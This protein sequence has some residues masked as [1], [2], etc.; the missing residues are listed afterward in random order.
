MDWKDISSIVGK[1]APIVG[2]LLGGPAG[3]AVGGLISAAL[4]TD[5]TPDAVSAALIGNP[6]AIVKIQELQTNAKV[7]LQQLAVTAE[8]NRLADVQSA[9][10]RQTANPNDKTP[11]FLAWGVSVGFF[12][13]LALVMFAKLEGAA[14]NLL[15]VMTGT[16]QTAWVAIISYYFGSSKDSAGKTQMIADVG[17]AA[18]NAPINIQAPTAA[19]QPLS[20]SPSGTPA[21][22]P[23]STGEQD[24]VPTPGGQGDLY[25]GS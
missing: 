11:Q 18:A 6:D 22:V 16:L 5:N 15:L 25:R 9:R 8:A 12:A 17:Y 2:T 7:Q 14:Q 13:T 3:M 23:T 4:G 19:A 24:Y 1:A 21:A 10:A 20:V